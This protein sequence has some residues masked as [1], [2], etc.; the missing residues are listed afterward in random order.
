MKQ[1]PVKTLTP[2]KAFLYM[3]VGSPEQ[4]EPL[5]EHEQQKCCQQILSSLP[6]SHKTKGKKET[7]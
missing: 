1:D 4:L 5:T 2:K 3:R 6:E 7:R